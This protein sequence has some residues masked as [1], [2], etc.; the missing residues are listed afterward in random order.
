MIP[1]PAPDFILMGTQGEQSLSALRGA[2]VV[3]YFYPRD[4][5]P[6]CTLQTQQFRDYQ[7]QFAELNTVI[8][9]VSR[10]SMASHEKFAIKQQL[11]FTLLSD[12]DEQV[13]LAYE[14]IKHKNL[15]GKPV[16]GIERSTFLI[17]PKGL[18]IATWRQVKVKG[19]VEAVL[20]ELSQ[21]SLG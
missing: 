4:A 20:A 9:G 1:I 11:N 16:R 14:V 17:D 13:C 19:H 7:R 18:I 8:L 2:Y 12:P 15:Y 5:T 10:D 6:G 21:L 3:L